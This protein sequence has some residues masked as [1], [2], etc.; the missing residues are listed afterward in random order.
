MQSNDT[1]LIHFDLFHV[2]QR[3]YVSVAN[4]LLYST[5]LAQHN[6]SKH[7]AHTHT[8]THKH[9]AWVQVLPLA[10]ANFLKE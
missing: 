10:A 6:K 2:R 5:V 3:L 9:T 4:T 7:T 1:N 8:H